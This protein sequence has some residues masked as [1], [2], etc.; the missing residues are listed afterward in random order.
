MMEIYRGVYIVGGMPLLFIKRL[1]ALACSDLHLGYEG[2]MADKGIFLPKTNLSRIE[3]MLKKGIQITGAK[4]LIIDGDIKN[5]FSK[6]HM[7]EFN[8]FR[9]F[10]NF[11]KELNIEEIH[12]VKGNHDNFIDRFEKPF[13]IKIYRQEFLLDDVLFFHGEELPYSK[14]GR[15]LVMGHLHP[16]VGIFNS[17]GI[18]EKVK[19]FLYGKTKDKRDIII[20]PAMNYFSEGIDVNMSRIDDTPIFRSMLDIWSMQVAGIDY[21][22]AVKFGSVKELADIL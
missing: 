13:G 11:L 5:E 12:L 16:A 14:K 10:V 7:E 1:N 18:R 3:R 2:V 9:E 17:L 22:E 4:K 21:S 6:V 20:L 8:E 19:C 15:L